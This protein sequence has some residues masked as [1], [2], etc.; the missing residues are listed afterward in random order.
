MEIA[1]LW[2]SVEDKYTSPKMG[3]M[4]TPERLQEVNR[5]AAS[6][7]TKSEVAKLLDIKPNTLS[8]WLKRYPDTLKKAITKWQTSQA[9]A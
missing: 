6:G 5:Y 8:M 4:T 7:H 2:F 3:K 1:D 9:M